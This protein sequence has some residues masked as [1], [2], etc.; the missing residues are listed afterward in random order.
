MS[1]EVIATTGNGQP[2]PRQL[3]AEEVKEI[4]HEM[5][6]YPDKRAVGLEALK[7]VQKHQGWVS[8]ESLLAIAGYLG[9]PAAD[10]EGV[11]TFFNLVFRKPVGKHVI[12]FCDSVSCWI[13][14]C[15]QIR[16]HISERL[17]IDYGDT[18]DDGEFTFIPVPCLGDCDR[19]PVMMVG[20]NL[21]RNLTPERVDAIIEQYQTGQQEKND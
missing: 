20:P 19:A 16:Q 10:L 8:D 11:A 9:I 14:G 3:T 13:M 15:E 21:H 7:I 5:T 1:A 4:E 18:T 12:L 17:S 6:L 2:R